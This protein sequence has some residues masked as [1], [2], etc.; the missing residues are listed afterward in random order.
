MFAS[1]R[2][3]VRVSK[4]PRAV[5]PGQIV[6]AGQDTTFTVP[7]NV[8][9]LSAVAQ[10]RGRNSSLSTDVGVSLSAGGTIVLRAGGG[11]NIGDGGGNGGPGSS[12][13]GGG[14]GYTGDG[15]AG[16]PA[17]GG[18]QR[19]NGSAGNGG[20]GAGGPGSFYINSIYQ[21]GS[22]GGG[23]GIMG[24]GGSG[25]P[26]S[27]DGSPDGIYPLVGGGDPGWNGG[28]LAWKNDIAVTPGQ[29]ITVNSS[30]GRVRIL[31]GEGRSYPSNAGTAVSSKEFPYRW[32]RIR[33][34]VLSGVASNSIGFTEIE[35]R[36]AI[37]GADLTFPGIPVIRGQQMTLTQANRAFDNNAGTSA[38]G[39]GVNDPNTYLLGCQFISAEIV[40]EVAIT[41]VVGTGYRTPTSFVVESS[42]DGFEWGLVKGFTNVTFANGVSQVFA[43]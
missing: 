32:W 13:G 12:G 31:W 36:G 1:A 35:L 34:T 22:I 27:P 25:T 40:E 11:L 24:I 6:I 28:S 17:N 15:G 19:L 21:Q 30:A 39:S 2:I 37:G 33:P 4:T 18:T 29:I 9:S 20:G 43:L 14:G 41:M 42:Y 8:F 16:G 23:V 3:G 10:Q 38:T 26:T 5:Q 7:D